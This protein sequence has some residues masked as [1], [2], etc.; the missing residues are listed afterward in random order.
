MFVY[1]NDR[2][3]PLKEAGISPLDHGF[4]YGDGVYETVR[5][6]DGVVF[7][8][9]EHVRRLE[10]SA[11][12]IGLALPKSAEGIRISVY[13]TLEANGFKDAYLRITVSRGEGPVGLDPSLCPR[14]T[15][16]I[17]SEKAKPYPRNYYEAG[18][19]LAIVGTR[20][21]LREALDPR[22]KSLNFL[23]NILAKIEAVK[24]GAEEAVMLNWKGVL[25]EG[26]VS[27]LFFVRAGALCT[28]SAGS[29]ILEGITREITLLLARRLDMKVREGEFSPEDLYTA[30]EVF[31]TST[32]MEIMP[33]GRV[34][35]IRYPVG[36]VTKTLAAEYKKEVFSYVADTKAA[37]PSLWGY[38]E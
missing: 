27:N 37:G 33:A 11:S 12:L 15:Y 26:T 18:I 8:L 6:Y 36:P 29:G 17:Y 19:R 32:M 2:V 35:D 14:P 5:V 22:I 34:D 21:N 13:E 1:L 28:P 20:R 4:L 9:D 7:M 24:A 16:F 3:L 25:A 30:Q 38:N 31:I 10:R 23:N